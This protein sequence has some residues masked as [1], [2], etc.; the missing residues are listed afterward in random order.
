MRELSLPELLKGGWIWSSG[1]DRI[2][3]FAFFRREFSLGSVTSDARL[4]LSASGKYQLRV[5]GRLVGTGP[6]VS[7]RESCFADFY[8][9][10]FY[11]ETGA[12]TIAILVNHCTLPQIASEIKAPGLWCQLNIDDEPFL[13]TD[14]KFRFLE[15]DCYL[16]GTPLKSRIT[17]YTE[18]LDME[19]F[20]AGWS[21]AQF[22][23][24]DWKNAIPTKSAG[25]RGRLSPFP[26]AAPE[27][28]LIENIAPTVKGLVSRKCASANVSFATLS[29][30]G[31]WSGVY[32]AETY[33]FSEESLDIRFSVIADDS[34]KVF[35]NESEVLDYASRDYL[36]PDSPELY[37]QSSL[38]IGAR[39]VIAL[40]NGWNK[41]LVVQDCRSG[42]TGFFMSFPDVA[43]GNMKFFPSTLDDA[44]E[45]W[46]VAGPLR[47][48]Y[49]AIDSTILL[50]GLRSSAHFTPSL[51]NVLDPASL[52]RISRFQSSDTEVPQDGSPIELAQSEYLLFDI[53]RQSYGVPC[54][55]FSSEEPST[56]DIVS[57][58]RMIDSA[59]SPFDS[60]GRK[61]SSLK[62]KPG[63]SSWTAFSPEGCRYIMV[64]VRKAS[65]PVTVVSAS[66][67][68]FFL[69]I[70]ETAF[71]SSD[72]TINSIWNSGISTLKNC[73]LG[74][75]MD[76][77]CG[78]QA[79]FL[80]EAMI[81]SLAS[82]YSFGNSNLARNSIKQFALSQH[83]NGLIPAASPSSFEIELLDYAMLWPVWLA[84]FARLG[85]SKDEIVALKPSLDAL[86]KFLASIENPGTSLIGGG[87]LKLRFLID[88]CDIPK[89][90]IST[91]L[92]SLY[93]RA[94]LS[95]ADIYERLEDTERAA[96]CRSKAA[97]IAS[98]IREQCWDQE[99]ALFCDLLASGDEDR[100][101]SMQTNV[102]AIFG[103]VAEASEYERIFA[104]ITTDS[105]PFIQL[106]DQT[107]PYFA[108]FVMETFFALGKTEWTAQ[109]MKHFWGKIIQ[110]DGD[111]LWSFF[112]LPHQ[113]EP[114][115]DICHGFSASPNFFIITELAGIRP[116][117]SGFGR[118]FFKPAFSVLKNARIALNCSEG[119][120][121]ISWTSAEDGSIEIQVDSGFKLEIAVLIE[122]KILDK[123][124][125]AVGPTVS[126]LEAV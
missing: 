58:D 88:Y 84:K 31:I 107:T 2:N 86:L 82:F 115:T 27:S 56:I 97:E 126:I 122:P 18:L 19:S 112:P 83:E 49:S 24:D 81:Q 4:W 110:N 47:M 125:L 17:G 59:L 68:R 74:R 71:H 69:N 72:E 13:W 73:V 48:Q 95:S 52:L 25:E 14:S 3:S 111:C 118:I 103:G 60:S 54:L 29:K 96:E 33:I 79:Q 87:E 34:L 9:L 85:L 92:N 89:N 43:E 61:I 39:G 94:L 106:A 105:P 93:S 102:L 51:S 26:E 109:F 8:D 21:E 16:D 62:L 20:P 119:R 108:Y 30:K 15:G 100:T 70:P 121:N 1:S 44:R 55:E 32:A 90:G 46:T 124:T 99:R 116:D 64:C 113:T 42:R 23:D 22:Q 45:G 38:D 66:F 104:A 57:A 53:G 76:S 91:A 117:E 50:K 12:N 28:E 11:L 10:S 5:N 65:A 98:T 123:C 120:I 67:S 36:P 77:P 80:G 40:K 114:D 6:S 41:I 101:F 75:F 35:V 63:D 37:L 7:G 78:Y